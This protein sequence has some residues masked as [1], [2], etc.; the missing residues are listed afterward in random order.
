MMVE[1]NSFYY[2]FIYLFINAPGE[3]GGRGRMDALGIDWC[4][5]GTVETGL[6][7][8]FLFLFR[9]S[10]MLHVVTILMETFS[11][12]TESRLK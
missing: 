3:G 1:L 4:F 12:I 11:H 10:L 2:L 8:L 9:T 6:P 5:F 7:S